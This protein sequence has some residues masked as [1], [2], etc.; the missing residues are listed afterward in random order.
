VTTDGRTFGAHIAQLRKARG[1]SQNELAAEL[2]VTR[3][4]LSSWENDRRVPRRAQLEALAEALA[5]PG[6]LTW[7]ADG[8]DE[9][10]R[11]AFGGPMSLT[12][13]RRNVARAL[14][15]NLSDDLATDGQPGYGWRHE[16]DD[17]S[18]RISALSTAFGLRA[19]MLAGGRDWQVSQPRVRQ[20]LR[21]LELP[22]GGWNAQDASRLARPEVTAVVLSALHDAGED[23]RYIT[24]HIGMVTEALDRRIQ[25]AEP[26]RPYV[27]AS[28]LLELSRLGLD[29]DDGRRFA[30]SLVDLAEPA[31]EGHAWPVVVRPRTLGTSTPST[32]HTACA[33]TALTA[34]ARRLND[35]RLLEFAMSGRTWLEANAD[36]GL[37]DEAIRSERA[38]GGEEQVIVRHL[39][40]A[41]VLR[42]L[43]DTGADPTDP[44][45]QA[46]LRAVGSYYSHGDALWRW[47]GSGGS[48]PVW[49]TWHGLVSIV[50]WVGARDVG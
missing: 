29:D 14:L 44:L 46:A 7:S 8:T 5:E 16:L 45:P 11:P 43:M 12:L 50:A 31:D 6:L 18:R 48:F 42:A 47:P 19:V 10:P 39:T 38:D 41:W 33:V 30:Q 32:T 28:T 2:E 40:P 34:W 9:S 3:T 49:M 22:T 25:G 36:L 26:A 27:L 21:R 17:D 4:Q 20:M 24:K 37:D 35:L 23:E 15:E 13:L 1:Y